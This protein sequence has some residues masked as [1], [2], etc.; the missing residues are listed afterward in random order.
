MLSM[1]FGTLPNIKI[2]AISLVVGLILGALAM[3]FVTLSTSTKWV[4]IATKFGKGFGLWGI[5][6]SEKECLEALKDKELFIKAH[7]FMENP[8]Y[9]ITKNVT[10]EILCLPLNK[11]RNL[12]F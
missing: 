8:S 9:N 1:K 2:A 12:P 5:Y 11:I 6:H 7:I 10:Q 4:I 3:Y